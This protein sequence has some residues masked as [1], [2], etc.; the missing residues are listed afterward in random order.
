MTNNK[1]VFT[2]KSFKY[3]K[4]D[5]IDEGFRINKDLSFTHSALHGME[6]KGG[7]SVLETVEKIN[8]YIDLMNIE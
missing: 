4:Y 3:I 6:I 8:Q 1:T 5:L 2:Y 7:N